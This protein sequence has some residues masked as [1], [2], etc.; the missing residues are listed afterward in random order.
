MSWRSTIFLILLAAFILVVVW[1]TQPDDASARRSGPTDAALPGTAEMPTDEV[2]RIELRYRDGRTMIFKRDGRNWQQTEP[3]AYPLDAYRIRQLINAAREVRVYDQIAAASFSEEFTPAGL[4]L[5]PGE[6]RIRYGWADGEVEYALGRRGIGGRAYIRAVED[7]AIFV[8][9]QNMHERILE[10]DP[11]EWRDRTL[12]RDV[13]IELDRIVREEGSARVVI[14]RDRRE[15]FL[16]EPVSTRADRERI[17]EYISG[18]A[19]ARAGGF[20]LD[21]PGDLARFGLHAPAGR[22]EIVGSRLVP[23]SDQPSASDGADNDDD[24]ERVEFSQGLLVGS[25]AGGGTQDRYGKLE[26]SP[27]VIRLPA[28]T[29][30]RLFAPL[31]E[32]VDPT[33]T[34]AHAAD[35]RRL[36]IDGP[37][38]VFHL[39]RAL[40]RWIAPDHDDRRVSTEDVE[41][42]LEHLTTLRAPELVVNEYPQELHVASITLFG[43]DRRPLDTVRV[44]YDPDI[45]RWAFE[46]GDNILR[47]Q[48]PGFGI[49]LTPEEFGLPDD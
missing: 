5:E 49:K 7:D 24:P 19:G 32:L 41:E 34:G 21:E 28:Q 8:A 10:T 17:E 15:W 12:F 6:V 35:V 29:I 42:L 13:S 48:G 26:G 1:L 46:N 30:V 37:E 39:E 36:R 31:S 4:G 25:P 38:G 3:F 43:F 14:E 2:T 40:N 18:L 45:Q 44:A 33:G 11:R 22:I 16:R 9:S 23:R 20:V 27:A 47:V